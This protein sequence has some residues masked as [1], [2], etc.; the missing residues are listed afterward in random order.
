MKKI[1]FTIFF[2][3]SSIIS[4]T[5]C[6]EKY[7]IKYTDGSIGNYTGC[8]GDNGTPEGLGININ[9]NYTDE[10]T[11]NGALLNGSN[12]KRTY[13]DGSTYYGTFE[14]GNIINGKFTLI[15]QG[16]KI[17]YNGDFYNFSFDGVG[18][19][20]QTQPNFRITQE[21]KFRNNKIFEGEEIIYKDRSTSTINYK[22]GLIE[23]EK[24]VFNDGLEIISY[25]EDGRLKDEIRNDRNYYN[26]DDIIGDINFCTVN[27]KKDGDENTG[28]AYKIIM[29]IDDTS[30]EWLFDTGAQVTSIGK[31]MFERFVNEGIT[32]KDLNRVVKTFGVGGEAKGKLIVLDNVKVG[33]YIVNNLIVKVSLQNNISLIGVDFLNKFRNIEW[34]MKKEELTIYK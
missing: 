18:F 34:D 17:E 26:P 31:R 14:N 23:N 22:N 16:F 6:N 9:N 13:N 20:E 7:E 15:G 19:L 8:L 33:D 30:G 27:L 11:F 24:E 32:Y 10:G 29:T 21:G 28:I 3:L 1:I 4:H 5:Q 25:Y 12:C 2:I